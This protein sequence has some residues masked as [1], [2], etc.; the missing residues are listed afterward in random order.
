MR[1]PP[2]YANVVSTM[3]LVL[4]VSGGAYAATQ[5]PKDSVGSKQIK[6]NKVKSK[7]IKDGGIRAV[8]LRADVLG[9][10]V[11]DGDLTDVVRD[12]ELDADLAAAV[13]DLV[14]E[15]QLDTALA[16]AL[17]D[18]VAGDRDDAALTL[19]GGSTIQPLVS[20][21]GLISVTARCSAPPA[22]GDR[23]L[24]INV[25][26]E[27]A[28]SWTYVLREYSAVPAV[29]TI[30]SDT[31]LGGSDTNYVFAPDDQGENVRYLRITVLNGQRLDLE[32]SAVTNTLAGGCFV[33][34]SVFRDGGP[35]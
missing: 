23:G 30:S 32:V 10:V 21:P 2:T 4:A 26:N 19:P 16:A 25:S 20:I 1:F 35:A 14:S 33:R 13:A 31:L 7:D 34:G 22:S 9:D 3:A 6:N 17:E 28:G 12:A 24:E 18:Y 27:G 5:L 11:R 8:D 15:G 29:D